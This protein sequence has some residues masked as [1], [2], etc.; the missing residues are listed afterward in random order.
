M[1]N[2]LRP[3]ERFTGRS[4]V[5]LMVIV[6]AAIGFGVLLV[7]VR[8]HWAPL[9][10][11]DW[12]IADGLNQAVA[13][14]SSVVKVLETVT[15]LGGNAAIWWLATVGAACLLIRRQ[16]QLAAYLVVVGAGA[17]VLTPLVK[18]VV[19]RLR[20]VVPDPIVAMPGSSSFPSGHT[21]NAT[22]FC[23]ALLLVFLP[24]IPRRVRLWA[25]GL[26]VTLTFLV[27]FSR[28]A[29]GVHYASDVVGGW[30]LGIA[31][32][33][34][35]AY[36]FRLWR[37]ESGEP[38]RPL[39]EG[40]EPEAAGALT[41]TRFA[42]VPH[43]VRGLGW[44]AGAWLVVVAILVGLGTLVTAWAPAFDEA[45]SSWIAARRTVELTD[46]SR[47]WSDAG[48]THAIT[49]G[50]L[51]VTPLAVAWTRRW[52]PA[53]FLV[54]LLIGEVTIFVSS[55]ALVGRD[56]PYVTLL[57]GHLPTSSFP[58]GHVAA[59]ACLYGGL[60]VL[61]VPRTRTWL[62]GFVIALAVFMPLMIAAARIYRGAHHPL[63]VTGGIVL[64]LLW[65]TA[66]TLAVRPNADLLDPRP[67]AP[68][69]GPAPPTPVPVGPPPVDGH[70]PGTRS[71]V[72]ANP[73]KVTRMPGRRAEIG[74]VLTGAGWA[75]PAWLETSIEDP[76]GSQARQAVS[77]GAGVVF[78]AGGDGTVMACANALL[79]TDVTLAV[80]PFGT[81]NLLARNLGVPMRITEAVALATA[82]G[83]RRLD[84]GVV[85]D[86]CFLI[87]AGMGLDAA[88]LHDAP[89][90]LKARIGWP[91][92]G[93]AALRHLCAL[94]MTVE[95]SL[96]GA[97]PFTRQARTV[98]VGN[99]G[100][101]QGGIR[102]MPDAV[103][104]D[105]VLDVAILMPPRRRNW[106]ALAWA[107]TR[108]RRT[109]PSMEVFQ[110]R[111]IAIRSDQIH[112][113][114]L[115]GELI[116]PSHAMTVGI[117]PGALWLCVPPSVTG[118]RVPSTVATTAD[119][120][121]WTAG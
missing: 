105:G 22:V 118:D 11:A 25:V 7:L 23:G 111:H 27:G 71:A 17:L 70:G 69:A 110:A 29:L 36:A 28:A 98:L 19:E 4:V 10:T 85:D 9:Q 16:F 78:A 89:A 76:G 34:I 91:A 5:G 104:D 116:E 90:A 117:H 115:D 113:R 50:L 96:D 93:L 109:P 37:V 95:I 79:G 75:V 112:P 80:L 13:S 99:C 3:F 62:R 94:P 44:L 43:V 21:L 82:A 73:T 83:R 56:R 66:V 47:F 100:R 72:V 97:Q 51:I 108:R 88:M 45:P 102:L 2:R 92:Y 74:Q 40:L 30:L 86:R 15:T 67:S 87:M 64:A 8:L 6:A 20:P 52:R 32:L 26:A 24:A 46:W 54:V 61:L 121:P 114:Q 63:D 18:A 119:P 77:D 58:S 55:A 103:P 14:R 106:L 38:E 33:G 41:P 31:W 48:N 120:A 53:V 84:V 39:A 81:G 107:L 1:T 57:D 101:L 68:G 65:V 60:A 12:G 35:T 49:L 42:P 59:T